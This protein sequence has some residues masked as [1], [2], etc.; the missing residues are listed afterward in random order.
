MFVSQREDC[1]LAE[2]SAE[3]WTAYQRQRANSE[4][5]KCNWKLS[6]KSSH[7]PDVLLVMKHHDD[8]ASTKK[9]KR[10][11]KRMGKQMKHGRVV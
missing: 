9:K 6:G 4:G 11:E 3:R 2:K 7:F 1:V 10:F 8:R 5:D